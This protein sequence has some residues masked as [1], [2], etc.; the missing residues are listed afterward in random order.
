MMK[1]VVIYENV[2]KSWSASSPDLPKVFAVGCRSRAEA[3]RAMTIAIRVHLDSLQ[4]AGKAVPAPRHMTGTVSATPA[5]IL[6][7]TAA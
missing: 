5:K 1:Y 3:R 2:G 7:K 6:R 4:K